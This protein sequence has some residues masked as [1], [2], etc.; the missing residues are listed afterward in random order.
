M[1]VITD[2][3][4]MNRLSREKRSEGARIC[5]V[6]TMGALHEGHLSLVRIA[7]EKADFIV[8]SIFVNPT[9]F[10]QQEDI[11]IY[12]RDLKSDTEKLY[13]LGAHVVFAPG[14]SSMYPK[15]YSTFVSVEG[16]SEGLCGRSRPVHFRGVTTVVNKLFVIVNPHIA[17]FGRK[18][19]QQLA[20][21]RRMTEDLNMDIEITG[22]PIIREEDGLA[23][24][25]RNSYLNEQERKQ[26]AVIYRSLC[27]AETL[28]KSGVKTSDN[29]ISKV[30]NILEETAMAKIEYID[31]VDVDSMKSVDD[32]S[33]SALLAVAV[34]FG[35][36]RLIDNVILTV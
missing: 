28:V 19:A 22:G 21:I 26:A 23:M 8:V 36:T 25:S 6:P 7:L 2:I 30:R 4:E 1:E 16:L 10:G 3:E 14:S 18:D 5:L 9:Q 17:V 15:G 12:P 20:V 27:A 29:I 24:S 33:G 13:S 34:W 11:D 35:K 32:I 31:I